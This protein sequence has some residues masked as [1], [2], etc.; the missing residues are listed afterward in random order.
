[1]SSLAILIPDRCLPHSLAAGIC[2]RSGCEVDIRIVSCHPHRWRKKLK[3]SSN[4]FVRLFSVGHLIRYMHFRHACPPCSR[5]RLRL[6][7]VC[8]WMTVRGSWSPVSCLPAG[9]SP[10]NE[11]LWL[12]VKQEQAAH[13][14]LPTPPKTRTPIHSRTATSQRHPYLPMSLVSGTDHTLPWTSSPR[15]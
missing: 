2:I 4:S 15:R 1:M 13:F 14:D 6:L 12:L 5:T 8:L 9:T 10:A 7:V 11:G 3:L